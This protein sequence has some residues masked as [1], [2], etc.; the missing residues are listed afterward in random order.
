MQTIKYPPR[1]EW[2]ELIRRPAM[3]DTRLSD[4]VSGILDD[5]RQKGD[6]AVRRY[7][8]KFDQVKLDNL[9]LSEAEKAEAGTLSGELK[10]AILQAKTNIEKFHA[11][12]K[13]D[14][15]K[16]ETSPGVVCWQKAVAIEKI[17]LYVPGG[18]AP[19][20]STVLM[21]AVP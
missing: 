16:I 12:Q 17:G 6:D 10:Q 18:T 15:P 4:V 9:L 5:V 20:F 11:A 1:S 13:Q 21:L 2:N 14:L 19:L 8:L 7:E 3:D